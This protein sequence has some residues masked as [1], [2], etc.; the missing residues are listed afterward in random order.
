[1]K[2]PFI[3]LV[4]AIF[5]SAVRLHADDQPLIPEPLNRILPRIT[6]DM[7]VADA[8]AVLTSVYPKLKLSGGAW[9]G[10]TGFLDYQLD[11]RYS[12][13]FSAYNRPNDDVNFISKTFLDDHIRKLR[14][15]LS[16]NEGNTSPNKKPKKIRSK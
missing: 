11:E 12:I 15:E 14:I 9:S 8:V 2:H 13:S 4:S 5:L 6:A 1:M 3:I 10:Q 7:R 16:Y